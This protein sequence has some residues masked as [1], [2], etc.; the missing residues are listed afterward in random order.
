ME[1]TYFLFCFFFFFFFSFFCFLPFSSTIGVKH[2][3]WL[4]LGQA[5]SVAAS[6]HKFLQL[7]PLRLAFWHLLAFFNSFP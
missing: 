2:L 1:N 6:S 4:E 5:M 7:A 3:C